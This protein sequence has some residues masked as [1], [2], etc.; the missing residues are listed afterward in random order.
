MTHSGYISEVAT[1]NS[2]KTSKNDHNTVYLLILQC[3]ESLKVLE[4][5]LIFSL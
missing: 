4:K 1:H 5:S 3:V 2:K